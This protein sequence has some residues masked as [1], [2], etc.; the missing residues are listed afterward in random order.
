VIHKHKHEQVFESNEVN[1]LSYI[2]YGQRAAAG[3]ICIEENMTIFFYW[4]EYVASELN[5]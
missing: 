2:L 5:S 3:Q 4:R 1:F